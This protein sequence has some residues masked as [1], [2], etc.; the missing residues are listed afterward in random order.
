MLPKFER[1]KIVVSNN[2]DDYYEQ[3]LKIKKKYFT[4][5]EGR[6]RK[7]C[8]LLT[9]KV[10]R[11]I[12]NFKT[13]LLIVFDS[14]DSE[15]YLEISEGKVLQSLF[16]QKLKIM[17]YSPYYLLIQLLKVVAF[18]LLYKLLLKKMPIYCFQF[19]NHIVSQG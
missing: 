5:I 3:K 1:D 9:K 15:N 8:K 16:L 11:K 14:Y 18:A 6:C 13:I 7:A 4:A 17:I 10:R 19:C 12:A 2:L